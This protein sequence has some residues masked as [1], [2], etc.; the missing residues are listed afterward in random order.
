MKE[1]KDQTYEEKLADLEAFA[2]NQPIGSDE[3]KKA[4]AALRKFRYRNTEKGKNTEKK[5]EKN[6]YDNMTEEEKEK[7]KEY[8]KTEA[9]K[10]IQKKYNQSEKG[11]EKAR[12]GEL[13]RDQEK[14]EISSRRYKNSEK[15]RATQKAYRETDAYYESQAKYREGKREE[16]QVREDLEEKGINLTGKLKNNV[17]I[18]SNNF[19]LHDS[20]KEDLGI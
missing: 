8:Q 1:S 10:A 14:K 18:S 11:K 9:G 6:R 4:F 19:N 5:Y 3:R 2:E 16:R 17:I 15:G 7:R 20:W 13:N 12:R